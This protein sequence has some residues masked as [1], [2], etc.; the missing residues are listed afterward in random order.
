MAKFKW[1]GMD[2]YLSQLNALKNSATGTVKKGV[3]DG[4]KVIADEVR[5]K[6]SAN[7]QHPEESSGDLL[8]SMYLAK[9]KDENG[10]IYSEIG[11]AGY[12]S[13][14]VPNI[15]KVHAME[16]GTS[17]QKKRPFIRKAFN[18]KQSDCIAA[19]EKRI[20]EEIQKITEG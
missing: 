14:G 16:S 10:Y 4:A 5:S 18:A 11:F 6:L 9:M 2:A 7:I 8:K 3:F 13:R 19:M 12:D 1:V 20:D 15:V 17:K